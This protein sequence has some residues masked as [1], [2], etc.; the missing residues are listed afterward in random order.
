M[1]IGF[2]TYMF[3]TL[4]DA[5]AFRDQLRKQ[6]I[7]AWLSRPSGGCY[8]WCVFLVGGGPLG[9]RKSKIENPKLAYFFFSAFSAASRA[10]ASR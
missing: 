1:Y 7:A 2:N 5:T 3:W 9:N 6:G 10:S 4:E 8:S